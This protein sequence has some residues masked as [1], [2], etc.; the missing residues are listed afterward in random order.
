MVTQTK[1]LWKLVKYRPEVDP[2]DLAAAI[3]DELGKEPLDYRTRLLIR[4]SLEG[5]RRYWGEDRFETWLRSCPG[6]SR[7]ESISQ[8]EFERVGFPFPAGRLVEKTDPEQIRSYLRDLGSRIDRPLRLPLGGSA[9]LI[10]PGYL[11]RATDDIDVVD[12]VP[13]EVRSQPALL[14][15]LKQRYRLKLAHFQQHY[16]PMGWEQRLHY[17]DAFGQLQVYLVDVYDVFLSKLYSIR[18]KDLDDMRFLAP[19]LDRATLARRLVETTASMLAAPDLRQRAE[20]N[21]YILY[22][23]SLPT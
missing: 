2:D 5:L 10:L 12:E 14:E 8:E 9:A 20:R 15:Q 18:D 11:S 16:L 3:Q 7:I 21:W 6:R 22:G 13:S 19:Q 4:D 17:L 1:D 23:E